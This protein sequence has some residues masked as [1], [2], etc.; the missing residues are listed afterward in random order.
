MPVSAMDSAWTTLHSQ[1]RLTMSGL[2]ARRGGYLSQQLT[3][4][5]PSPVAAGKSQMSR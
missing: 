3:R 4:A 5:W 1:R 2:E